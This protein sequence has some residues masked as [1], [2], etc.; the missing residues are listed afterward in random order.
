MLRLATFLI[1][2]AAH[3]ALALPFVWLMGHNSGSIEQGFGDD[4]MT[5][6]MGLAT[7]GLVSMGEDAQTVAALDAV[8][9]A[10]S[11]A[12]PEL[13][14]VEAPEPPRE[15]ETETV[16]LKDVLTP[17]PE[18]TETQVSELQDVVTSQ[19]VPLLNEVAPPE[20]QE[21]ATPVLEPPEVTPDVVPEIET[22]ELKPEVKPEIVPE[23]EPV[24]VVE[25][26]VVKPQEAQVATAAQ[27]SQVAVR[28]LVEAGAK[29]EAGPD[30]AT[31]L[32]EYLG[33][34]YR[35]IMSY[36]VYP[37]RKRNGRNRTGEVEIRVTLKADGS[38]IERKV[39]TS[40]GDRL[41][42]RAGLKWVDKA[43]PFPPLRDGIAKDRFV[44][45]VP[46][47]FGG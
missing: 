25:P 45:D 38:I 44:L 26:E 4:A 13:K 42:D 14:E 23:V 36:R 5:I 28:E 18:V 24:D 16:E 19:A 35:H 33:D 12:R 30:K 15:V 46:I 27:L 29:Q 17:L 40:S 1:S 20:R 3:A 2:F 47:S 7:E 8:P 9:L 34:A 32:K 11:A 10:P 22:A 43:A 31:A 41:L 39:L 37:Q 6:E 21:D